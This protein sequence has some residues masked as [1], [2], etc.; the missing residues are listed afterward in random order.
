[1]TTVVLLALSAGMLLWCLWFITGELIWLRAHSAAAK[2]QLGAIRARAKAAQAETEA[3]EAKTAAPA[4]RNDVIQAVLEKVQGGQDVS[5]A[6]VA[7]LVEE[8]GA[9]VSTVFEVLDELAGR[10]IWQPP[11]QS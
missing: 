10:R 7:E 4:A 8:T 2:R 1:M 3:I 11:A 6:D 9:A 5:D